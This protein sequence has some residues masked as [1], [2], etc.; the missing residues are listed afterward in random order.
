MHK[1]APQLPVAFEDLSSLCCFH[2]NWVFWPLPLLSTSPR[3]G[4]TREEEEE[5]RG[6]GRG[7]GKEGGGGG[8]CLWLCG[9]PPLTG[10]AKNGRCK[11]SCRIIY[12]FIKEVDKERFFLSLKKI[13]R[14]LRA[15]P[16]RTE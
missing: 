2:W 15:S 5:D 10:K 7:D 14:C 9:G 6:E 1:E 13:S 16:F 11:R 12:V 8:S 3:V 4:D